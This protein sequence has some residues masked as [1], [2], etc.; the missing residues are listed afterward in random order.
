MAD[1]IPE[2][3]SR[4]GKGAGDHDTP[5]TWGHPCS[6]LTTLQ[7]ARLLVL[8]GYCKDQRGAIVGDSDYAAPTPSGLWLAKYWG[9]V[10]A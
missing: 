10:E 6:G 5:W 1:E 3:E 9:D 7:Q 4:D 2:N 8:R